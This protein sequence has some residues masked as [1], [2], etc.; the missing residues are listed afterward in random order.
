MAAITIDT[1]KL[2]A[3][4]DY[5]ESG[6]YGI[7]IMYEENQNSANAKIPFIVFCILSFFVAILS[8]LIKYHIFYCF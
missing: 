7:S 3:T 4:L 5:Y 2:S 6:F 1:D 8:P